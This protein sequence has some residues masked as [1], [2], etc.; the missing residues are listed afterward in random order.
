MPTAEQM[1]QD[2]AWLK[3][4]ATTLAGNSDDADDLVQESW[5]AAWR[6]QPD[7]DRPIR[8]WLAKVVRDLAGMKHR[9]ERRRAA[10]EAV[11]VDTRAGAAPDELLE[12]MRL[13]RLLVDLVLELGEPY[14]STVIARFV[15]GR[16]SAS[17]ARSL[18]IPAGTVRKRLREALARLR[19]GL[20]AKTGNRTQWA[21]AVLVFAKGGIQVAKPTKLVVVLAA[22]FLMSVATLLVVRYRR[23]TGSAHVD[24]T[25]AAVNAQKRPHALRAEPAATH[26]AVTVTD[27]AGP[28]AD[29][30]IRCAP[31]DGELVIART[32]RDGTASIDL[33]AGK[34]TIAAS[35]D[36]HEPSASKVDVV[37][38][39]DARVA[40]VLALGGRTLTGTVTDAGGGLVRG[41]RIDAARLD[42]DMNPDNAAAVAVTDTSGHYKLSLGGGQIVVAASHPDYAAQ[43]RYV[44]LGTSG[45]TANF[46]L[47]PGGVLE[48]VVRDIQ[49]KQPV[50]GASVRAKHESSAAERI[51]AD[52]HVVTS[53]SEGEFRIAGLRPGQYELSARDGDQRT[54]MP[55]RVG[56]GVAEQ[57][58]SIVLLVGATAAIRGKVVDETGAPAVGVTVQA[59]D[60]HSP[61]SDAT[62]D[63]AGAFVLQGLALG[64]WLLR[65]ASDRFLAEGHAIAELKATDV[66][67]VV[68]HVRR[69]LELHGHVSPRE[70]CDVAVAR[71]DTPDKET[72]ATSND[73]DFH[74]SPLAPGKATVTARCANGDEGTIEVVVAADSPALVVLVA[75]GA[76]IDGRVV[77]TN[78]TPIAG[79]MVAAE[80]AGAHQITTIENGVVTS[81]VKAMTSA[82][83]TFEIGRL[84]AVAYRLLVLDRG[85]PMRPKQPANVTLA[86]GQRARIEI[87]VER[88]AG[89][90][91]GTVTGPDGVA[92]ADAWVALHLTGDSLTKA[93][94]SANPGGA[95]RLSGTGDDQLAPALTDA[96][97]HFELTNV[98]QGEYEVIAEAQ[99]GALRGLVAGV[100]PDA[101]IAIPLVAAGSVHGTVHGAHGPSAL[102]S[103]Q[104]T[105]ST[106]D[107]DR[108][109]TDGTFEFPRLD[110]GDYTI[111][112]MS[113]DGTGKA[114]VHVSAGAVASVDIE[115]VVNAT[116]TGRLVDA[117]GKP[118]TGMSVMLFPDQPVDRRVKM[119]SFP[120]SS[121][122]DGRFSV[123]GPPGMTTLGVLGPTMIRKTGLKLEPGATLDL[124]DVT[125]D[126]P[127]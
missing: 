109:F 100:T 101:D 7:A 59:L 94:A 25:P 95:T 85:R 74:V 54:R 34:W 2:V 126:E 30:M 31:A 104:L 18:G 37:A 79:V 49:T 29:A 116:V 10:R 60:G 48:G 124:G 107:D 71:P 103:I 61:P 89:T 11:I 24:S 57:Q 127:R 80:L 20:D 91:N 83:G 123:D 113:S 41:A 64:S 68:V 81:G 26:V 36:R 82:D 97:G 67:G 58:A 56:L 19:V 44:D 4:L 46:V 92:L 122:P 125:V 39:R 63:E 13:H 117:A 118:I 87:V 43:A 106:Y 88:P 110:P 73:G 42:A 28:I 1:L 38:G 112:V 23:A 98:P 102:F 22:L 47:A 75:P 78:G 99:S 6:R 17:I 96:R 72:R 105:S 21:P 77:D 16:T 76:A 50:P 93:M 53:S 111:A 33:A 115:L 121:G 35:A 62:S 32:G 108:S 27:V 120:P 3:R 84:D 55:V 52:E 5:I 90:I 40:L 65:G 12:Q 45:A 114:T 66:D 86:N 51:E 9:S 119:L 15:E 8:P 70:L 14:R 69:G